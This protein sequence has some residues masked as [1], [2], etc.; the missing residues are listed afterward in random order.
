M[1]IVGL[2]IATKTGWCLLIEPGGASWGTLDVTPESKDE[3]E[4]VRFRRFADR[5]GSI[6]R[7]ADAV[8]IER[9]YS[10]GKRTAEILNGLTAVA[11]VELERQ[12]IE[13][14][15]VD[16]SHLKKWATGKGNADKALMIARAHE[17]LGAR[18]EDMTDDEADAYHLARYG[19]EVLTQ[20]TLTWYIEHPTSRRD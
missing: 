11:L 16:A 1:R 10:R 17:L 18:A 5:I 12:G 6:V 3:P 13:Y 9:T 2:D 7:S 14:A 8:I 15:F 4:G 20:R 19:V